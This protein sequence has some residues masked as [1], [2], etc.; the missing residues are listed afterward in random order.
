[1]VIWA[2]DV[3]GTNIRVGLVEGNRLAAEEIIPAEPHAGLRRAIKRV[4]TVWQRLNEQRGGH[5]QEPEAVAL[6]LPAI[7][8]PDTGR[9][10]Q[11]PKSK[12]EDAASVNL[13]R[14]L[15]DI[16]GT[17]FWCNDA[18]AALAGEHEYGDARAQSDVVMV[19]LGTGIGSAVML[20]G[21]IFH[22]THGL[23]GNISGHST[24]NSDGARCP[25]GNIG[26]AELYASTWRIATLARHAPGFARSSLS[27]ERI[28]DYEIIFQHARQGDKV[29]G[30]LAD[31]AAKTWSSVICNLIHS[32]DPQMVIV[33]G[34]IA[35]NHRELLPVFRDHIRRHSWARWPVPIRRA[36]LGIHAGLIGAAILAAEK[37][38]RQ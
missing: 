32:Y 12:Y 25:C 7:V 33:G 3:G 9:I 28:I 29:A 10:Y 22:G 36:T 5:Y 27:T 14:M 11:A 31:A 6:A 17:A 24:L 38:R 20:Q 1:M 15:T 37:R 26:C 23:A 34:G 13:D 16:G 4:I 30:K 21:R 35:A 18:H 19:T 8:N 2:A